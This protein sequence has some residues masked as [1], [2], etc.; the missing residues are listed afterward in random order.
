MAMPEIPGMDRAKHEAA[1][2]VVSL[3]FGVAVEEAEL[4][5]YG[6][7]PVSHSDADLE[8]LDPPRQSIIFAAGYASE[9]ARLEDP[10][11]QESE[12]LKV[13]TELGQDFTRSAR[14]LLIRPEVSAAQTRIAEALLLRYHLD[15][16]EL[17]RLWAG[18]E[19]WFL[20]AE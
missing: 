15:A 7:S 18:E 6:R 14:K 12:D 16:G 13:I 9:K 11:V 8:L 20:G 19:P 3:L 2:V 17:R 5:Y 1:H 10:A 4:R